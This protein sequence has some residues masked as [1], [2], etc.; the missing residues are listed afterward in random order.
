M[1]EKNIHQIWVGD[2][3]IPNHIQVYMDKVRSSHQ[4]FTYY[5]WNDSNLPDLP[6]NLKKIYDSYDEPAIKAD[7]LRMYVV[8]QFGGY[9]LDADF[10]T[11]N[12]FHL[13]NVFKKDSDGIIVYNGSYGM[14]ALANSIFGFS[15]NNPMLKYLISNIVHEQQWIGPNW[16]A[17]MVCKHVGLDINTASLIDLENKLSQLNIQLG[18]WKDIED[19]CFRHEPLSSWVHGSIWNKKLNDGDYD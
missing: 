19:N 12:G 13:D 6:I 11:L 5:L 2:K 16:W 7:L 3:K 9:Y 10:D 4:D 18:C 17:Q 8:S 15:K 1:I 14:S